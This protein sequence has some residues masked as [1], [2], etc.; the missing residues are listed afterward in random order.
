[1]T[2]SYTSAPEARNLEVQLQTKLKL[3]WIKRCC[4]TTVVASIGR[5]LIEQLHIINERRCGAFI[6]SIEKIEALRY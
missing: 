4:R 1:M 3:S 5:T 2:Y 6:E